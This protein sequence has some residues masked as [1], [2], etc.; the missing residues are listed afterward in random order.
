MFDMS[1]K[2]DVFTWTCLISGYLKSGQV[3]IARELFDRMPE[4]NPVSWGAMI[5]GHVEIGFFKEALEGLWIK[6]G[7]YMLMLRGIVS[8]WIEMLGT[9]LIDM[10]AKCGCIEM[11]CSVFDEMD[12]RDVYAFTCLIS[13]LANHDKSEAAIDL[14]DRMQDEGVVPN[15]V[16]FVCVLNACSRMGMVAEGLRIFESMSNRY[17]IDPTNPAL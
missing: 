1:T 3:L 2:R 5:T 4:K 11:A 15:E 9:A 6:E 7:G 17:V 10:Y 12:D 14:F 16:T 8:H 13:G